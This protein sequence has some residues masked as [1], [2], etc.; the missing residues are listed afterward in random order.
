MHVRWMKVVFVAS[1]V[2]AL[3]GLLACSDTTSMWEGDASSSTAPGA[4]EAG[5]AGAATSTMPEA[6]PPPTSD[7]GRSDAA[8]SEGGPLADAEADAG[9]AASLDSG[10][11]ARRVNWYLNRNNTSANVAFV[12]ANRS[13]LTGVYLCCNAFVFDDSGAFT[14]SASDAEIQAQ[15]SPLAALGLHVHFVLSITDAALASGA[16]KTSITSTGTSA[17]TSPR[18]TTRSRTS[19]RTRAS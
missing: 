16:Y 13:S 6:S 11:P 2:G 12:T 1:V 9:E 10:V 8:T 4:P 18:R 17:T 7:A 19:R 14:A 15:V 3:P 5:D